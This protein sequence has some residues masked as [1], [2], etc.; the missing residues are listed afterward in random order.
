MNLTK[1]LLWCVSLALPAWLPAAGVLELV[2]SKNADDNGK[3]YH[4]QL[5]FT[6]TQDTE[7]FS[8]EAV[9]APAANQLHGLRM[10]LMLSNDPYRATASKCD[11]LRAGLE[12][13]KGT[14]SHIVFAT[15]EGAVQKFDNWGRWPG[16]KAVRIMVAY[17]QLA[18]EITVTFTPSGLPEKVQKIAL[19]EGKFTWKYFSL[20]SF[21]EGSNEALRDV[22][23]ITDFKVNGQELQSAEFLNK[24][25]GVV[26]RTADD[27]ALVKYLDTEVR[28]S[29]PVPG[30]PLFNTLDWR[31]YPHGNFEFAKYEIVPAADKNFPSA[32]R[33]TGLKRPLAF[34]SVQIAARRNEIPIQK[35]DVIFI[36]FDARCLASS[37]ESGEGLIGMGMVVDSKTWQDWGFVSGNLT[38]EWQRFYGFAVAK[39]DMEVGKVRLHLFLSHRQ[40]TVEI[41]GIAV[42]DLGQNIDVKTL[43][44]NKITY[45][46]PSPAWREQAQINIEKY[47]KGDLTVA[48]QS[49][50]GKPLPGMPVKLEMISHAFGFGCYADDA[51]LLMAGPDGDRFRKEFLSLFNQAIVPVFWGPGNAENKQYGWENPECRARYQSTAAWCRQNNLMTQAHVLTWPSSMYVPPDV[52]ALKSES[53]KLQQRT[54]GHIRDVINATKAD[55]D[56][57][58]VLN[59]PCATREFIDVV[60]L[61][62]VA[63]WFKVA[64]QSAPDKPMLI[65]DNGILSRYADKQQDYEKLIAALLQKGAKIDGIGFQ[66][67]MGGSPPSPEMLWK[68]FDRFY[69][70]FG[71]PIYI[72]EMT[73]GIADEDLQAEYTADF[74]LAAFSHP[75]VISITQWGF[76][77]GKHYD[78]KL[79]LYRKNWE[80]K[81]NGAVYRKLVKEVWH[82]DGMGKTGVDGKFA[83]RAFYGDYR[84]IVTMP[85]GKTET[86][87]IR[88]R[89]AQES[90]KLVY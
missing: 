39:S 47:R 90:L 65:N 13:F 20:V 22:C 75:G 46:R 19:G 31:N 49:A 35:G 24:P 40:Q 58:Q 15:E 8:C 72:T 59:E 2:C 56:V 37:D 44:Q 88:F 36:Q 11:Y 71:K 28:P 62:G 66:G 70:R 45:D 9:V 33:M 29:L 53:A 78:A 30:E 26:E 51:P 48:L 82:T 1:V 14:S 81:P 61:D 77:A 42:L 89:A 17:S 86:R 84:L 43:P 50:D 74:L 83:M 64:K 41:G 87:M 80:E 57:Y 5:P 38:R 6:V 4:F 21:R 76:W 27:P 54:L 10:M 69:N 79:A 63:E 73:I 34:H 55:I 16:D 25:A 7:S 67:H 23:Q 3:G 32:L 52:P 60:G 85:D 68:I 12:F 18:R